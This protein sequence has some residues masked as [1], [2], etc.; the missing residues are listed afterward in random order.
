M[1]LLN[2][3][4]TRPWRKRSLGMVMT[5]KDFIGRISHDSFEIID[6][7]FP[8]PYGASCTL[9]GKVNP[10][11]TINLVTSLHKGFRVLFLFWL[12]AMT[13]LV[14]VFWAIDSAPIDGL[15]AMIIV[16]P[17]VTT[18]FRLFLHG[19]YVLARNKG[20]TKMKVILEVV[21]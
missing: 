19:M 14:L 10:N 13:V 4:V 18:F 2:D 16:I 21:D 8:I 7:S 9:K 20:L 1:R 12:I 15:F 3:W 6:S 5:D 11:S 17:I